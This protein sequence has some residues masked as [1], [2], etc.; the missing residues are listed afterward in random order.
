MI[1]KTRIRIKFFILFGLVLIIAMATPHIVHGHVFVAQKY[2]QSI[3]LFLDLLLAYSFYLFYKH[4]VK[5]IKEKKKLAEKELQNSYQ[6]IGKINNQK[7]LFE[8]FMGLSA[9]E[10]DDSAEKETKMLM[11]LFLNITVSVLRSRKAMLR[12]ID[13]KSAR[14]LKEFNYHFDGDQFSVKLSNQKVL[15]GERDSL[16]G[17][18]GIHVLVGNNNLRVICALCYDTEG[19]D[20]D[21]NKQMAL[22]LLNQIQVLFLAINFK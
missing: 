14:T 9:G 20:E 10:G 11:P 6:Y 7:K 8:Q 4:D 19:K 2:A 5:K 16:V 21:Q 13:R 17:G 3:I 22:A 18:K 15:G 1:E 12:F